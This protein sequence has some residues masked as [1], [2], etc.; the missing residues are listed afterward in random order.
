MNHNATITRRE[1]SILSTNKLIRNTYTLLSMTLLFSA[2]MA[3]LAFV[4]NVPYMFSFISSIISLGLLWFVLPKYANSSAGIG[5]TFL[6]TGLL[7]FGL[8]PVI[9]YYLAMPNGSQVVMTAMGG[10]GVIFL[11]LSGYALTS[12][13]DFSFLG[14]F[15][16][17]G[18]LVAILASIAGIFLHMPALHLAVSSMVILLM[19]GFIL[20]ET[21]QL[22]NGGQNNYI[23]ATISLY[24]S[25]LNIFQSLLQILGFF[26]GDE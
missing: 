17:C 1:E 14:G 21:S 9:S 19:S 2:V 22:V 12:R 20:Y 18:M 10:T 5:L 3:G 23:L 15:L 24:L 11:G 13:K 8:G 4:M 25:I 7:G 16:M 6:I 26:G